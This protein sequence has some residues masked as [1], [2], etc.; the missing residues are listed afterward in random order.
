[1]RFPRGPFDALPARMA[2]LSCFAQTVAIKYIQRSF[3]NWGR[4]LWVAWVGPTTACRHL[5]DGV[6]GGIGQSSPNSMTVFA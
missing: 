6:R 1:V 5:L 4:N 3:A 2:A